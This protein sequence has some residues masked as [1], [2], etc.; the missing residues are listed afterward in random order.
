MPALPR[1]PWLLALAVASSP[2]RRA[3]ACGGS[4]NWG[5]SARERWERGEG[6]PRRRGSEG[7]GEASGNASTVSTRN[8]SGGVVPDWRGSAPRVLPVSTPTVGS[9]RP[10]GTCAALSSVD[11][12]G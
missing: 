11:R 4:G 5:R 10:F 7:G 3:C 2:S 8:L 12:A 1:P 6:G 9:A